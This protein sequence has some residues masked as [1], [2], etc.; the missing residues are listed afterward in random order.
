MYARLVAVIA[1]AAACH[2]SGGPRRPAPTTGAILGLVRDRATG[3]PIR[4]AEIS[5]R[6]DGDLARLANTSTTNDGVYDFDNLVPGRYSV[7]A[8]FAGDA[9]EVENIQ[10]HAGR[11]APVD[12]AF[13]LGRSEPIVVDYGNA[14]DGAIDRYTLHGASAASGVIEGT[15]TDATTRERVAGAVVTALASGVIDAQQAVTDDH[16]RFVFPVVEPGVYA[17]SAYYTI[18][19]RGRIEVLRNNVD[20]KGGEAV[21]VPLWVELEG[22]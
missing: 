11:V 17:V 20:V 12:V 3:E 5:L 10:V 16:G 9:V 6:R 15:V 8:Y 21:V 14:K 19:R 18:A 22:Q 7:M 4:N 13:E 1:V 2:A